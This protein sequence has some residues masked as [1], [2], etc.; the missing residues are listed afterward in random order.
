[1]LASIALGSTLILITTV[2][3]AAAMTFLLWWLRASH[4]ERWALRTVWTRVRLVCF[5]VMVLFFASLAEVAIWG[6]TYIATGALSEIEPAAYFSMVTY[7]S[8]GYGDIVLPKEMRLL[9]SFEAAC[10]IM[11]FG[12]TTALIFAFVQRL[13]LHWK[14]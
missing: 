14:S 2:V 3:H 12:W 9:G 10:G 6:A 13:F 11:M 1:M 7:T 8:L 5:A 4:A